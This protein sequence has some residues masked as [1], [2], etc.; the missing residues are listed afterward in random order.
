MTPGRK[1]VYAFVELPYTQQ[2]DVIRSLDIVLSNDPDVT[3]AEH[4][5]ELFRRVKKEKLQEVM[6]DLIG[7][8]SKPTKIH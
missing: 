8:Y 7:S 6:W 2:Q 4:R 3:D 1:L 5:K